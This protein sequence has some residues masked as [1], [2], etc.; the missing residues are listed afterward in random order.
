MKSA[1]KGWG[2]LVAAA[3]LSGTGGLPAA[4]I[5]RWVD[6]QGRIHFSDTVP[7]AYRSR[8]RPLGL[9]PSEPS[10]QDRQAALERAARDQAR[11]N[12]S[13]GARDAAGRTD[14]GAPGFPLL[15]PRKR[16]A[17]APDA[18]TDCETWQRLYY[19]SIEC[20]GPY[21]TV[22]GGIKPEAFDR[23]TEVPEPPPRCRLRLPE[24]R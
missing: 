19:E 14:A 1:R 15:P 16:P 17:Q 22:R 18:D 13:A 10:E 23:C 7:D 6:D 24:A 5:Y 21:R 2:V 4:T 11:A 9:P 8:A 12:A 20:F 3:L